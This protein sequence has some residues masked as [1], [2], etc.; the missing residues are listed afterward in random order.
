MHTD[1]NV[2]RALAKLLPSGTVAV[3]CLLVAWILGGCLVARTFVRRDNVR[4]GLAIGA[5]VA[6]LLLVP[7][8]LALAV[9]AQWIGGG[10][11]A[12]VLDDHVALLDGPDPR[13]RP[14]AEA[15]EGDRA[16]VGERIGRFVF[17]RVAG[18][19]AGWAPEGSIGVIEAAE[20]PS[21]HP[22]H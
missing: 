18:R 7:G 20:P 10:L 17:I 22:L 16:E 3:L 8:S 6:V 5:T 21:E 9:H 15:R 13:A 14:R 11:E 4:L 2:L 12:I 19:G 1:T